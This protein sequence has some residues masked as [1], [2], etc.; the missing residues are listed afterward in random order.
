MFK[1]M[2]TNIALLKCAKSNRTAQLLQLLSTTSAGI[3]G[4]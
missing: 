4:Q 3:A 1:F 2:F